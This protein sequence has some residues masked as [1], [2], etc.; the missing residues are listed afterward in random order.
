MCNKKHSIIDGYKICNVCEINKSIFEYSKNKDSISSSCKECKKKYYHEH[1]KAK[2]NKG[3]AKTFEIKD[4]KKSCTKCKELRPI[5]QYGKCKKTKSGLTAIC[6]I[7]IAEQGR[8]R[9]EKDPNYL[10]EYY[11]NNKDRARKYATKN[12]DKRNARVRAKWDPEKYK[13]KNEEYLKR[14]PK[15][16]GRHKRYRENNPEKLKIARKIYREN[17]LEKCKKQCN[18]YK[19]KNRK[20]I[21]A[22]NRA[23]LNK[24]REENPKY[25]IAESISGGIRRAISKNNKTWTTLVDFSKE[26]FLN[27]IESKFTKG[28]TW[29]NYGTNGWHID[30][31]IPQVYF[32]FDTADHPAFKACWALENLQPL[33][34]STKI[35]IKHGEDK[36]YVGN[37]DKRH[38]IEITPE[39]QKLLDEVNG[40]ING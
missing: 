17:N 18:D 5:N 10:K 3:K 27:H 12:R 23:W 30:H 1:T 35:A 6:K 19:A 39:I 40:E 2:R 32:K 11:K 22:A 21:N 26:E 14:N 9:R 33:W 20:S 25:R 7:C 24:R 16:R 13:V 34:S 8:I 29:E 38:M 36:S 28:M 31:I 4:G 37:S 15:Q